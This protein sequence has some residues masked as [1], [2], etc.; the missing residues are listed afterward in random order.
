MACR[1]RRSARASERGESEQTSKARG[2]GGSGAAHQSAER[3]GVGA[4][5][6]DPAK[7]TRAELVPLL[8]NL[9]RHSDLSDSQIDAVWAEA[10]DRLFGEEL[11]RAQAELAAVAVEGSA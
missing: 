9:F 10:V 3:L 4:R 7:R 11:A 6:R 8:V 2:E 5:P 1:R